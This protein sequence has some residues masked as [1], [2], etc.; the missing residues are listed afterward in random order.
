[1][2]EI[3]LK[4]ALNTINKP[5]NEVDIIRLTNYSLCLISLKTKAIMNKCLTNTFVI[6]KIGLGYWCFKSLSTLFQ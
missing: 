5:R 6:H 4:V 3:L 2:P 1:M